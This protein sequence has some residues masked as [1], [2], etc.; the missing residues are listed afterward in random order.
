MSGKKPRRSS[1]KGAQAFSPDLELL[2]G[3]TSNQLLKTPDKKKKNL[4]DDSSTP[5]L[6]TPT[7][8]SGRLRGAPVEFSGREIDQLTR[9]SRSRS[10]SK[11]ATPTPFASTIEV[12]SNMLSLE[13]INESPPV[14]A[15]RRSVRKSE[16]ET[17]EQSVKSPSRRSSKGKPSSAKKVSPLQNGIVLELSP[18]VAKTVKSPVKIDF[19]Q[20]EAQDD[21]DVQECSPT[22]NKVHTPKQAFQPTTPAVPSPIT[23]TRHSSK[24]ATSPAI[25]RTPISS[26]KKLPKKLKESIESLKAVEEL[27]SPSPNKDVKSQSPVKASPEKQKQKSPAQE[28]TQQ[29]DFISPETN[30]SIKKQGRESWPP[31]SPVWSAIPGGSTPPVTGAASKLRLSKTPTTAEAH[32]SP[33]G[34]EERLD[35]GSVNATPTQ[36]NRKL[37]DCSGAQDKSPS[38]LPKKIVAECEEVDFIDLSPQKIPS[39]SAK[40]SPSNSPQKT[41]VP[42][43]EAEQLDKS[44]YF[45]PS[46]GKKQRRSERVAQDL[47]STPTETPKIASESSDKE[48]A[49]NELVK[50]SAKSTPASKKKR[51]STSTALSITPPI[52]KKTIETPT[53]KVVDPLKE[54]ENHTCEELNSEKWPEILSGENLFSS[55]DKLKPELLGQIKPFTHRRQCRKE[56]QEV[57]QGVQKAKDNLNDDLDFCMTVQEKYGDEHDEIEQDQPAS[58]LEDE[59]VEE[60]EDGLD[61]EMEDEQN[62]D[63]DGKPDEEEGADIFN[64][65]EEDLKDLDDELQELADDDEEEDQNRTKAEKKPVESS[66]SVDDKFFNLNEMDQFLEEQDKVEEKR[67]LVNSTE[68]SWDL[69]GE[70]TAG[71]RGK[72]ELL[73]HFIDVDFRAKSAPIIT[74]DTTAELEAIIVK[75][76]KDKSFDDVVRKVRQNESLIPMSNRHQQDM[77]DQ[78]R[79]S[80]AEVY[81][82]EFK[83][84]QKED[85]AD[86]L[87]EPQLDPAVEAINKDLNVLF[88][89]L[90]ALSHYQFTPQEIAPEI[91]IVSNMPSFRAEEVGPLAST[92]P[93]AELLAPEEIFKR[94]ERAKTQ[95][96]KA[97]GFGRQ[98]T[99]ERWE[100]NQAG[101]SKENIQTEVVR[102]LEKREEVKAN[103]KVFK[104]K[105]SVY[106]KRENKEKK[107]AAEN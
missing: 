7:R 72:D 85:K 55:K 65:G 39:K 25:D 26:P 95:K 31:A 4:E 28:N 32:K 101:T 44:A 73:D 60:E 75:R 104:K 2:E 83:D 19:N 86:E 29:P 61:E 36:K 24:I 38:K 50:E 94:E 76:I 12:G 37:A 23:K 22:K 92:Q 103:A 90:D 15:Q 14:V 53:F 16:V 67:R 42:T 33:K 35:A 45:T 96:D 8:R 100:G 5:K 11:S 93:D 10:R 13:T 82:D 68:Q 70:V 52:L 79:K 51:T 99:D 87:I 27:S 21:S 71:E 106:S 63:E 56:E 41:P 91:K 89:K 74:T 1:V 34:E 58:E 66:S 62:E 30:S 97:K 77:E 9:S 107:Q 57:L 43:T 6:P 88:K 20:T 48:I 64:L 81:E 78:V 47:D 46:S 59:L 84:K 17:P 40:K 3:P 80:L 105:K 69:A 18:E 54:M 102:G 98:R 49:G